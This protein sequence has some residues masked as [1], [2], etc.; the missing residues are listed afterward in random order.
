VEQ[1]VRSVRPLV[2]LI[3]LGIA[4]V[5]LVTAAIGLW[6]AR[7]SGD[8]SRAYAT[9]L[10]DVTLT[11]SIVSVLVLTLPPSI[12]APRTINLIPFNELIRAPSVVREN[13]L[14][15]MLLNIVL[16]AP[17]GFLGPLKWRAIDSYAHLV[18][19]AAAFSVAIEVAQFIVGGGRQTSVTDV[20]LN[21]SGALVGYLLFR[22]VRS[23][24]RA[25][26]PSRPRHHDP[27]ES[28][29]GK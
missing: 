9:A 14:G 17:L 20:I 5:F 15:Q 25:F 8:T 21:T 27:G 18:A 4:A 2:P 3:P 16:F 22:T 23:V 24:G 1:V 13:A 19:S 28:A 12:S 10:L 11:A 29:P 7:G 6:R 26:K